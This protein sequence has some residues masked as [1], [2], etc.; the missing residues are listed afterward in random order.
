MSIIILP[1]DNGGIKISYHFEC[2][3]LC[4]E[5]RIVDGSSGCSYH[6]FPSQQTL[7]HFSRSPLSLVAKNVHKHSKGHLGCNQSQQVVIHLFCGLFPLNN[8][9]FVLFFETLLNQA[10]FQRFLTPF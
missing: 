4:L 9:Q 10:L 5:H 3:P 6:I 7:L 1:A 2:L 8:C